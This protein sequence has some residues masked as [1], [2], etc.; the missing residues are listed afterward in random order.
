MNNPIATTII[1]A[2]AENWITQDGM[3]LE[4]ANLQPTEDTVPPGAGVSV[5]YEIQDDR[6]LW[7]VTQKDL[8]PA[9]TEL[10]VLIQIRDLL[11]VI[12]EDIGAVRAYTSH[13]PS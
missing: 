4:M 12:S 13:I 2:Q 3:V 1:A 8:P 11:E 5:V 10:S 9:E 6:A 7:A